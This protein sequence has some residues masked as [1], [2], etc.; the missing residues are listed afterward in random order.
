MISGLLTEGHIQIAFNGLEERYSKKKVIP[1]M[2]G[3]QGN[4]IFLFPR[5]FSLIKRLQ[6]D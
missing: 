3:D 4:T 2:F 1:W 6:V 5:V